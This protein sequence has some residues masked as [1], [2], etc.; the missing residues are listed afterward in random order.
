MSRSKQHA[1]AAERQRAYRERRNVTPTSDAVT[2]G[3]VTIGPAVTVGVTQPVTALIPVR[4]QPHVP[5][6]I[7]QGRGS[8]RT[9]HGASYVLIARSVPA[10]VAG[11]CADDAY[12]VIPADDWAA[13]LDQRCAHGLQGW[14]CHAC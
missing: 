4:H 6:S 14:A 11:Q 10:L 9:Y 7:F 8:P 12:A 1:S 2:I 5:L 13:R 3:P